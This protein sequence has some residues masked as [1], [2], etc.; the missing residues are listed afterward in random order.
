MATK[1]KMNLNWA[2]E[3]LKNL[4]VSSSENSGGDGDDEDFISKAKLV[5][6]QPTTVRD[7]D[8]DEDSGA[9]N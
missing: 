4:D 3:Y 8:T 9:E 7:K 2:L 6:V 5:I 1:R